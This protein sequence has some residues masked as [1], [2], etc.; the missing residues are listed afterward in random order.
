[1]AGIDIQGFVTPEQSF[2]GVYHAA[3]TLEKQRYRKEQQQA[4]REGRIAATG[5]FLTDYLD[6][7]DRLTGTNYDPEIVK[8]LNDALVEGADLASKGADTASIIMALGPKVGKINEYSQK[9][10]AVNKQINDATAK[11]KP[12]KGYNTDAISE[13][14]KKL[15]FYDDKG[16]LKDITTVDPDKDWVTELVTQKPELATSG[17]GLDEFVNKT[18]MKEYGSKVQT[19]YAGKKRNVQY[20]AK[21][22]FW[23]DVQVD[24]DGNAV[25]DKSGNPVGLDVSGEVIT[26]DKHQPI[27][28]PEGQPYKALPKPEYD[29]IMQH[30][31][32]VADFIRGRVREKFRTEGGEIPKEGTPQW[33]LMARRLLRDELKTRDRSY[34]KPRDEETKSNILTKIELGVPLYKPSSGSGSGNGETR[35]NAFD[36]IPKNLKHLPVKDGII[37]DKTG[38]GVFNGSWKLNS[39][40]LP[41]DIE[42]V[43]KT[44][45]YDLRGVK[46]YDAEIEGGKIVSITPMQGLMKGKTIN[47]DDME[48]SQHKYYNPGKGENY[49]EFPKPEVTGKKFS[50]VDPKTGKVLGSVTSQEEA[51]KA[52][53]KGY[54]VQ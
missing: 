7:K 33:E 9:A 1:M 28:S 53:A 2:S 38:E 27:V 30:N 26:D 14:A 31:P 51:D 50:I 22:P 47:R 41:A 12:L 37:Y 19:M 39:T 5:K 54:K 13:E 48:R 24:K 15:A 21:S 32:D 18:P 45:G 3:D 10:K 46:Q 25:T 29:A 42:A 44:G 6:P 40:D 52:K 36:G 34:F 23:M 8:Q 4:Q 35:G 16:K 20:D 43:L 49:V 11:L 17:A